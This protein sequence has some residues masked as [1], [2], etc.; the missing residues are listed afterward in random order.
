MPLTVP[1]AG[2]LAGEHYRQINRFISRVADG[3]ER[4]R[5]EGQASGTRRENGREIGTERHS[6]RETQRLDG[7]RR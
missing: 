4:R 1:P 7:Q 6:E 5:R 3:D 2:F